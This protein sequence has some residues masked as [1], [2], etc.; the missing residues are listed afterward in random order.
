M[1]IRKFLGFKE[2][3]AGT[4]RETGDTETV[5]KITRTLDRLEPERARYIA[6]FAYLLH[7][8]AGADLHISPHESRTIQRILIDHAGLKEAES[9]LILQIAR[10]QKLHHGGTEDFLVTREFSKIATREQKL[11][12]LEC[13]FVV[14]AAEKPITVVEDN[15]IRQIS[16]E[17]RLDHR[18]FVT[19][20][21]AFRDHLAVL[22]NHRR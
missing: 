2:D 7:R 12:L 16:R 3:P 6:A 18:D 11:A 20:R 10:Q 1:S 14:C 17:I 4:G 9:K 21:S 19:V 8:V 13:L 15:E 22:K 5:R